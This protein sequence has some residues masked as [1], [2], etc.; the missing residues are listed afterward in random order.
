ME[1]QIVHHFYGLVGNDLQVKIRRP[2]QNACN[3]QAVAELPHS[4][5]RGGRQS[6]CIAGRR[7]H[8]RPADHASQMKRQKP[9]QGWRFA[10]EAQ[11]DK[12]QPR[13]DAEPNQRVSKAIL[14][15]GIGVTFFGAHEI[16]NPRMPAPHSL[17][18]GRVRLRCS[19][20]WKDTMPSR[21]LA[22]PCRREK[23]R[24]RARFQS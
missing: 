8:A 7:S 23:N 5:F 10:H 1:R 13:Q 14:S 20:A 6:H 11:N 24:R 19:S 12:R 3:Y 9:K 18:C 22:L 15:R 16:I 2:N 21:A 4:A 17:H